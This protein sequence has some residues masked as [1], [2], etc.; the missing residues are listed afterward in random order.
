MTK[1][2]G[3]VTGALDGPSVSFRMDLD[4]KKLSIRI[5]HLL[6]TTRNWEWKNLV[7]IVKS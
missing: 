5:L 4:T 2:T 6:Q 7:S 3:T 1:S